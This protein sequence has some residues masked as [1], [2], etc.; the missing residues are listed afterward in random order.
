MWWYRFPRSNSG[1]QELDS[2]LNVVS[3]VVICAWDE[4]DGVG[5]AE[6]ESW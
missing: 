6:A 3:V 1:A 5:D 4:E 2:R